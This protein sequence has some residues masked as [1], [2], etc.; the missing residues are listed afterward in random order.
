MKKGRRRESRRLMESQPTND[1]SA[2][3]MLFLR[4]SD[5]SPRRNPAAESGVRPIC[6]LPSHA[7]SN[8]KEREGARS[9]NIP[10]KQEK[11]HNEYLYRRGTI[12]RSHVG[13]WDAGCSTHDAQ[14][15]ECFE[16]LKINYTSKQ[17]GRT[18]TK[19]P[20][21]TPPRLPHL[22]RN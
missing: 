18:R 8:T 12:T 17:R 2:S 5:V 11:E 6:M 4:P 14:Q 22:C 7:T 21:N 13:T 10:K 1:F 15:P 19:V 3:V 16:N 9:R 20:P